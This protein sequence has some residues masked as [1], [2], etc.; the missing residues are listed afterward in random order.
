MYTHNTGNMSNNT[1]EP[2]V[3]ASS[4]TSIFAYLP[5]DIVKDDVFFF[6]K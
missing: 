6:Y 2:E 4:T 3:P 5:L 1:N